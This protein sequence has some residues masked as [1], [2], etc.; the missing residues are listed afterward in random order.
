MCAAGVTPTEL[1]WIPTWTRRDGAARRKKNRAFRAISGSIPIPGRRANGWR[2]NGCYRRE[3]DQLVL[4]DV[5]FLRWKRQRQIELLHTFEEL[6]QR[7]IGA[8]AC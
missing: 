7:Q 6:A 1:P 3:C 2:P 8:L 5:Q 4:E